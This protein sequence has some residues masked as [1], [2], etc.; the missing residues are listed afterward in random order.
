MKMETVGFVENQARFFLQTSNH[1]LI[2]GDQLLSKDSSE[3]PKVTLQVKGY[4]EHMM[5]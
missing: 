1:D 3:P 5:K 4:A 2:K